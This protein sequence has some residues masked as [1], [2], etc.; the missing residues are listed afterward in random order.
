[1]DKYIL[2]IEE[3]KNGM[4]IK[5]ISKKYKIC[6]TS[7][8][9]KLILNGI[10]I[11][12]KSSTQ[13]NLSEDVISNIFKYYNE[14]YSIRKL[15][16][17]FNVSR[18]NI[19]LLLKLNEYSV[20][21]RKIELDE[22]IFEI[23]D[24]EYK[25]YWLGFIYAD[26]SVYKN[27]LEIGLKLSDEDHLIKLKKFLNT[28]KEIEYHTRKCGI[29]TNPNKEL[30]CCIL[31]VQSKKLVSNLK[32][33]GCVPKKSLILKFPTED[34]VPKNLI[35]HFIRGYFDGDGCIFIDK[36]KTHSIGF[37]VTGTYDVLNNI[38]RI[39]DIK[40]NVRKVGNIYDL[41]CKG[42]IKGLWIFDYLY[43]DANVYLDRKYNIYKQFKCR[44]SSKSQKS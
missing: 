10:E 12:G 35:H 23:I 43:K 27:R 11:R 40:A 24:S 37:Q 38:K 26:G 36:S 1:M 20:T 19:S 31:H 5:N 17:M 16:S 15:S 42:N 8:R 41:R 22:D 3:Y 44:L 14:G 4:S 25:A 29:S 33:L 7:I 13:K 39:L 2:A 30:Q 18:T 9:N 21:Q 6:P 32:S 28:N 34:I